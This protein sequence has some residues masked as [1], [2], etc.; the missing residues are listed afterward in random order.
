MYGKN[1]RLKNSI[2]CSP[3]IYRMN[4]CERITYELMLWLLLQRN[5]IT[6]VNFSCLRCNLA[7]KDGRW[8]RQHKFTSNSHSP[9]FNMHAAYEVYPRWD[10]WR[11]CT[12]LGKITKVNSNVYF[13]DKPS[14]STK[15][16]RA[17]GIQIYRRF[18]ATEKTCTVHLPRREMQFRETVPKRTVS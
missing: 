6:Q 13:R 10:E 2:A 18:N 11:D 8:H 12:V 16:S 15:H 17:L 4:I 5:H 9:Q 14:E 7:R 3:K 1:I